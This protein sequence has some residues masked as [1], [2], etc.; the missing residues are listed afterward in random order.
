MKEILFIVLFWISTLGYCLYV[1]NRFNLKDE[2]ILPFVFISVS[3]FIFI[4][5]ILN[6]LTLG[7]IICLIFGMVL[8]I[9]RVKKDFK[10]I[11]SNLKKPNINML[12]IFILLLYVTIVFFNLHFLHYDNFSHWA[13][14]VKSMILNNALPNFEATAI[15]FKAYQPGTACFI[16]YFS[17]FSGLKEG[18]MIIAQNYLV[19]SLLSSMLVFAKGKFK[20]LF[21]VL[22][23]VII[24]YVWTMNIL[25][26]DLLVDT[27]LSAILIYAFV[28]FFEYKDNY[29]KL[30]YILLPIVL[31]LC[32]VKNSGFIL[33]FIVCCLNFL[34]ALLQKKWKKGL[35]NSLILGFSCIGLLIIWSA[36]VKYGYGQLGLSSHHALTVNN[37]FDHIRTIG[38]DKIIAFIKLYFHHFLNIKDNFG[39]FVMLIT[40]L[41]LISMIIIF[42][43]KKD[44]KYFIS[45]L[46]IIDVIYLIYYLALGIMYI[47]SME[48]DGLFVLASFDRY[49]FTIVG[50]LTVLLAIGFI[51][52]CHNE[53]N[54]IVY[55]YSIIFIVLCLSFTFLYNKKD[56]KIK[57]SYQMF[58][59]NINYKDTNS[60]LF[61]KYLNDNYIN[62]N[63]DDPY[64]VYI[65][66]KGNDNGYLYYLARYKFNHGNIKVVENISEIN[67]Y[68]DKSLIFALMIDD[69]F[70]EYMQNIE[71]CEKSERIYFKCNNK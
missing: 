45:L 31:F 43:K 33:S 10:T 40:N 71:F 70:K 11:L 61:D 53:K 36:H 67:N 21:R 64:Y 34:V 69:E 18:M 12:I 13:T 7:S 58:V 24:L 59:G 22:I 26:T 60:Y 37:I 42:K 56:F 46:I 4:C 47:C 68:N 51:S 62:L 17:H 50:A 65:P 27:V 41:L 25:P 5:G 23:L 19:I 52:Y 54:L 38:I 9:T 35:K 39:N 49:L 30:L 15:E 63:N 6:I 20:N 55:I 3:L 1:K 32:L 2:L 44:K 48:E 28:M 16:Y 66:N 14:I 29:D 8:F 57:T